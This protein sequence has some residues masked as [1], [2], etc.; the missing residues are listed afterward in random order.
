MSKKIDIPTILV[1]D[2]DENI[3]QV[4]EA[5]L[6][7]SGL[8]P[9]L[10][11][12][13]ETALEM[14]AYE[15]VDLIISD[16]KMPGMGGQ[17]LLKEVMENWPHI[18][19]IMLTA[20][21]TIPDAVGSIQAGAADY[22]TKPFDGKELVRRVRARLEERRTT[23]PSSGKSIDAAPTG[24]SPAA[25]NGLLGGKAPSMARF[26]ELLERV[27]RS[28]ALV[29]LFGE[30]GTGKEKAARRLHDASPRAD[31]PFVV[32]DCGST[33]PTLLESELFGH[34]KGSFT[35]AVKDKKGLIEA[36][37]GGTLF[38]DEIGNISPD[39]QTRLLRFLQE[40]T[41]RRVGDNAERSV[42][43]RVVAAT[44]ANLPHMVAQGQ[45]R[46]D[47]YYRLKVV[48]LTIPP[49]RERKEDIPALAK[50]FVA[51]LCAHQ[52]RPPVVISSG[53]MDILTTHPWPGNVRELKNTLEA[54]L[55]FCRGDTIQADDLNIEEPPAGSP[56]AR[57]HGLSLEDSERE[58]IIHALDASKGVK[59][60]AADRLGI[61]RRAIHYKIKKYGIDNTEA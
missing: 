17:G 47:L 6:L 43:C 32:V 16:V 59:K 12:R 31:G 39:M 40:G 51:E 2:D 44:N 34:V 61:S 25:V 56:A 21:G 10:A 24:H 57:V 22:L 13:A 14:L 42:T 1:V 30:S 27:A 20:H 53:A 15:P 9:L 54:A 37:D 38:L 8:T 11:D 45:F 49:L 26:L 50:G 7:S 5:R 23:A 4:L 35:H 58:A 48:T 3:L 46:E 29:L 52:E 60:V 19:I 33:Q 28:T 41:I 36:A 18:P 55:V